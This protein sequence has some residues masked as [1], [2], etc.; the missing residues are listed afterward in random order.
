MGTIVNKGI[1]AVET[2]DINALEWFGRVNGNSY[3]AGSVTVN[4]GMSDQLVINM[5]FQYGYGDSYR[6]EGI[7]VLFGRGLID[8]DKGYELRGEGII[9]RASISCNRKKRELKMFG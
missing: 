3:F 7:K 4:Y 1:K 6:Y 2:I 5:P 9:I 8:S